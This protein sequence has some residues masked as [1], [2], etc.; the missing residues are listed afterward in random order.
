MN[1]SFLGDLI[2]ISDGRTVLFIAVLF[3]LFWAMKQLSV[4][5]V[6]FTKRI[7]VATLAGLTL[8]LLVQAIA[9]FPENPMELV[10]LKEISKWYSLFGY[11]FIDLLKMLVVPLVFVSILRVITNMKDS[12][13]LK[14]LSLRS[15]AMFL[16]TTAMASVVAILIGNLFQ[17]GVGQS[18]IVESGEIKEI[19]PIVD[20]LRRLLPSNPVAAMA[21]ANIVGIVI[22]AAFLGVATNR[23]SKKYE[24][25]VKP[26]KDL[27]EAFYKIMTS[28]AMSVIKLMPFAIIALLSVTII[29]NGVGAIYLAMDFIAALYTSIVIVFVIHLGIVALNGLNPF[30][31]LKKIAQVL[32]CAFTSCSSLGTLPVTIETLTQQVGVDNGVATFVGSLGANMGMNGCAGIYPTLLAIMIANMSGTTMDAGFYLML[33]IVVSVG[34]LGIAGLPGTATMAASVALSGMGLGN[35]FYLAG[36]IL[37]IDPILDM[38]RTMLNVNGA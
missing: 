25:E 22:F 9:A 3:A 5:K 27:V 21:N 13:Q 10:W 1:R 36:S 30:L 19:V 37:A 32:I 28:V 24:Q 7:I 4:R 17:L 29:E 2:M 34:S 18:I 6:A 33:V 26:F 20:T 8:G 35:Y 12:E 14:A 38:G 16:A 23:V 31:Y 11:G 15:V